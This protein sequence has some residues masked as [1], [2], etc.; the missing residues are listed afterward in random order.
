MAQRHGTV[1]R[2]GFDT[3]AIKRLWP[4][5]GETL[6][7]DWRQAGNMSAIGV[8]VE[9]RDAVGMLWR[10]TDDGALEELAGPGVTA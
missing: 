10:C 7:R 5:T 1:V 9:F 3:N 2:S 6:G 8:V 4:G